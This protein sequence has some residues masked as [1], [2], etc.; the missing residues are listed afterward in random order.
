MK[1]KIE[2]IRK[3]ASDIVNDMGSYPPELR[4]VFQDFSE[5]VVPACDDALKAIDKA[6][7][8]SKAEQDLK[9]EISAQM[10]PEM[11]ADFSAE[12]KEEIVNQIFESSSKVVLTP[13][14][15]KE[16]LVA[17]FRKL[18]EDDLVT[19]A[20]TKAEIIRIGESLAPKGSSDSTKYNKGFQA[21]KEICS[22]PSGRD[23]A[24]SYGVNSILS[25]PKRRKAYIKSYYGV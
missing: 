25:D 21:S 4:S 1:E 11:F 15:L 23:G 16:W 2:E 17:T 22:T 20:Y 19:S 3:L 13:E 24:I 6:K 14:K 12:E 7:S 10:D 9:A 18:D 8:D 5:T